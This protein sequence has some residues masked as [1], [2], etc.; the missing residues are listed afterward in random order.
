MKNRLKLI[1]FIIFLFVETEQINAQI[2]L[3]NRFNN[4]LPEIEAIWINEE[5]TKIK[6]IFDDKGNLRTYYNG[7]LGSGTKY[8]ISHS[9]GQNSDQKF[10]FLKLEFREGG[11]H[12]FEIN[13][14]NFNNSGILSLTSMEN[15]KIFLYKKQ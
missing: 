9:C 4:P 13:G 8:S 11:S 12:C 2:E 3:S 1:V 10:Y 5:D 7:K 6:W 15:G 14:V